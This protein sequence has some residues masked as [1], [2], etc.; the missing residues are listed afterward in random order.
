MQPF[1]DYIL[2]RGGYIIG[3]GW[4]QHWRDHLRIAGFDQE[5]ARRFYQ[6]F[7]TEL[8]F[9]DAGIDADASKNLQDLSEYLGLPHRVV[10]CELESIQWKLKTAMSR[11]RKC[12]L[13]G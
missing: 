12:L 8:V 6:E 11:W 1:I 10:P 4:L 5:T 7:S 9:F 2:Q 3:L 13:D